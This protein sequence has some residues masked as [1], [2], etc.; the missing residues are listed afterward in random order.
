MNEKLYLNIG[1]M[2]AQISSLQEQ[3]DSRNRLLSSAVHLIM[4]LPDACLGK[5]NEVHAQQVS[6]AA[7]HFIE[8][9]NNGAGNHERK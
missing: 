5:M 7:G 4:K 1:S 3:L 9:V 6:D 2:V 8:A